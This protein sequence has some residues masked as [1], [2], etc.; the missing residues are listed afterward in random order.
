MILLLTHL[1]GSATVLGQKHTI[2]NL[3]VHGNELSVGIQTTRSTSK[4]LPITLELQRTYSSLVS[5]GNRGFR[6]KDT[7]SSL[8]HN[9]SSIK[10][11]LSLHNQSLDENSISE[12]NNLLLDRYYL[13]QSNAYH[14][15]VCFWRKLPTTVE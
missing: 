5:L 12:R 14:I 8:Y 6:K 11:C 15:R 4:H 10:T 13:K 3:A 2:A 7:S 1:Q 9:S